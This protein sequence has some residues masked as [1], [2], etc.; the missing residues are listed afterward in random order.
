[1]VRPPR[2]L[3]GAGRAPGAGVACGGVRTSGDGA[4][5]ALGVPAAHGHRLSRLER[6]PDRR[7][8]GAGRSL[9]RGGRG[10]RPRL[11]VSP[12]RLRG[13]RAGPVVA[14]APL[15][16][17][18][19]GAM[20]KSEVR[21]RV[22]RPRETGPDP[23]R[24]SPGAGGQRGPAL[25]RVGAVRGLAAL[26]Q[27]QAAHPQLVD[28]LV[29]VAV[30]AMALWGP[31]S[32]GPRHD[33]DHHHGPVLDVLTVGV[34]AVASGALIWR[35]SRTLLVWAVS[36]LA[37]VVIMVHGG[38]PPVA[39]VPALVALYTVG[40]RF[41]LRVTTVTAL[42]TAAVYGTTMTVV[43]GALGDRTATLLAFICVAAAVGYAVRSQRAAVEA[44]E[45]R[46]RQAEA[47]REEEAERRVTDERLRIARDLHDIV[48]H[49]ISVVNVQAGVARHLLRTQ[50]DQA[51]NALGLVREASRTVLSEMSTVLGLLRTGEDE[52]PTEPAPGLDRV[53]ALIDSMR[54][55]GLD[56]TARTTR[57]P[58]TVSELADLTAYRA[59][60]ESLT[61]A[62]KHG[63]G[64]AE[65][66]LDYR[67][68]AVVIEVR[69][70]LR[71]DPS[72]HLRGRARP[73]RDAGARDGAGRAIRRRPRTRRDFPGLRGAP[74]DPGMT[75]RVRIADDQV[76][77][78]SGFAALIGSADD[79]EVV[80]E[81]GDGAKA[82]RLASDLRP[83]VVLMDIRMP[84]MDGLA[85][86]RAITESPD[87]AG[88][89]VIVLTTFEADEY[90]LQ[91]LRSGAS[92]FLGKS[93]EPDELL[94]AIRIVARGEA[95]LSPRATRSL[96]ARFL[97][98]PHAG[99]P[100]A[101]D[102]SL[103]VLTEREREMVALA[104]HGLSNEDIAGR[105][106]LSPLTVKTHVNRAMSK[107]RGRDRAQL[108]VLAYQTGLVRAGDA[109]PR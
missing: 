91:A 2:R 99:E 67:P 85:A 30:F 62:L 72:T 45:A 25:S 32:G 51:E 81:A 68:S 29:A 11:G 9:G 101:A 13:A 16:G 34:V 22:S 1:M 58:Y 66:K 36:L 47:T 53:D 95:L 104:A 97:A 103:D 56:V 19:G 5:V 28:A 82:L 35:R 52:H 100:A 14:A 6:G 10:G 20:T 44:A 109:E 88:V 55:S 33:P 41:P 76:L 105:L 102:P 60:Q 3:A 94:D 98:G 108:V 71:S 59:V 92:G 23:G 54:K 83:D 74:T 17:R 8:R 77:I 63:T 84:G 37:A 46:A 39:V 57:R 31:L 21:S 61:N 40:C 38:A 69:T 4:D 79:I 86:S 43:D 24:P 96:I 87:L 93:V 107:L 15:G 49:H 18:C 75:R 27:W 89:R 73:G 26:R 90:V 80:G 42:V 78:R 7:R 64:T 65:L 48:A 70:P 12:R 50:P 106:Y